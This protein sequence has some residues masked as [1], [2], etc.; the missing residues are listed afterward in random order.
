MQIHKFVASLAFLSMLA[1]S[2]PGPAFAKTAQERTDDYVACKKNGGK[3]SGCCQAGGGTWTA[4]PEGGGK[5]SW[6]PDTSSGASSAIS[7]PAAGGLLREERPTVIPGNG[8]LGSKKQQG[9]T[10]PLGKSKVK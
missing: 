7:G 4:S 3:S 6:P 5:C 10:F 8:L 1:A 9:D 2:I